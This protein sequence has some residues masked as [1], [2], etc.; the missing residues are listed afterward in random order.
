M[1]YNRF[2]ETG[3]V[4]LVQSGSEDGKLVAIVDIIDQNRVLVDGPDAVRGAALLKNLR[5]TDYSVSIKRNSK[6]AA[7]S[8]AFD[9]A[10][11]GAKF[12]ESKWA[13]T[14]APRVTRR[15]LTDFERFQVLMAKKQRSKVIAT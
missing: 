3:R 6:K 10:K 4:A 2:V 14:R 12:A 9:E 1:V 13:K 11:V 15:N 5:L 7:V 8:K